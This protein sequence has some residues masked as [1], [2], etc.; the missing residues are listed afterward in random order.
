MRGTEEACCADDSTAGPDHR[1]L[2]ARQTY[3]NVE[4]EER[5]LLH[6]AC[7]GVDMRVSGCLQEYILEAQWRR[8]LHHTVLEARAERL[9]GSKAAVRRREA[10]W[11]DIL[12]WMQTTEAAAQSAEELEIAAKAALAALQIC[13]LEP[14]GMQT[15]KKV[16]GQVCKWTR[17]FD[18]SIACSSKD[19]LQGSG[20]LISRRLADLWSTPIGNWTNKKELIQMFQ[21]AI[22]IKL[23]FASREHL[24]AC[25]VFEK[26]NSSVLVLGRRLVIHSVEDQCAEW[27]ICWD[28]WQ[29]LEAQCRL[30]MPSTASLMHEVLYQGFYGNL[31]RLSCRLKR[32]PKITDQLQLENV[33]G[34]WHRRHP[35]YP[36]FSDFQAKAR[37][38]L[39]TL[40]DCQFTFP[41]Y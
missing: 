21:H 33:I 12:W 41:Q 20:C 25:L 8:L 34:K 38:E 5:A 31:E 39:T 24:G 36:E 32:G 30:S 14:Y 16:I 3:R 7:Q 23:G 15:I 26:L 9:G 17:T 22:A 29:R 2:L 6:S 19:G 35:L 13:S 37:K 27:N 4:P 18:G 28:L 11:K 40:M 10:L 1:S